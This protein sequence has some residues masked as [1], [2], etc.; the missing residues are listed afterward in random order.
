MDVYLRV[1]VVLPRERIMSLNTMQIDVHMWGL[2]ARVMMTWGC[3]K[4]ELAQVRGAT[5]R[6]A[7]FFDV[8]LQT[9]SF[10]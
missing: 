4:R 5:R 3:A 8:L 2:P 6:K 9:A 1:V 7:P 10:Q